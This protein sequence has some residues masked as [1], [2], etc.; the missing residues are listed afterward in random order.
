MKLD[1]IN[2]DIE[3]AEIMIGGEKI[4]YRDEKAKTAIRNEK[5]GFVF[6]F[7]YLLNLNHILYNGSTN[8]K[9]INRG[10]FY[11]YIS[12]LCIYTTASSGYDAGNYS[13]FI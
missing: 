10:C 3:T 9:I 5:I 11:I 13:L 4:H 12:G 6:Q 7:H 1:N 8:E 2:L